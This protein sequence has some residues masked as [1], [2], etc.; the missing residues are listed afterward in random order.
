MAACLFLAAQR[1]SAQEQDLDERIRS[2]ES[3]LD[4]LRDEIAE[5]RRKIREVEKR[6]RSVS[7]YL[8]KLKDEEGLTRRLLDGLEEKES[9]LQQQVQGLRRD[10]EVSGK[11]YKHRLEVFSKRLKEI[12]KEGPRYM[13]QELLDANGFEDLLQ[14]YKFLSL[15][16]ERDAA[17]VS[18]VRERKAQIERKE[19]EITELL[20][21]VTVARREKE[22]ELGSLEENEW[23][24]KRTL[25][26]LRAR[27]QGYNRKVEE[28]AGAERELQSLIAEMEKRR[29]EQA[30]AWGA[31]GEKDFGSLRGRMNKPVDGEV[32]RDFG[33]YRHPEFGTV[34]FS[35]GIDI[36][37]RGGAPVRAVARGRVEYASVLP[38]YGN[39]IILNHGG[40][41]YTLYAHAEHV[42]VQEGEQVERSAVIAEVGGAGVQPFHFEIRKSKKALNPAAW[43]RK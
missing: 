42:F 13:W 5:Q 18:D 37:S 17:L 24:R 34:T 28:L 29:L 19:A 11:I 8:K 10:L 20:H 1:L 9:M 25:S 16:A 26:D 22:R 30:K 7:D 40:G 38:G 23:K 27:K 36:E 14:R 41:Y 3:E 33:E 32:V 21:E 39:C 4:K 15:V 43:L 2:K 6:E 12:Y 31:Y 35:T